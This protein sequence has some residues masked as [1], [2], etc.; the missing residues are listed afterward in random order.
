MLP[1]SWPWKMISAQKLKISA[2]IKQGDV[3]DN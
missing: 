2:I 1:Q 3:A